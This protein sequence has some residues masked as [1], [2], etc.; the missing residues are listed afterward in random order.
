M[1]DRESKSQADV[2]GILNKT[3][4]TCVE[5]IQKFF[6][7]NM[8][9]EQNIINRVEPTGALKDATQEH[10]AKCKVDML[11]AFIRVRV[12]QDP[13]FKHIFP[14]KGTLNDAK[15]KIRVVRDGK[16]I[17]LLLEM[18]HELRH[19]PVLGG[20]PSSQPPVLVTPE[21]RPHIEQHIFLASS[22]A[23]SLSI[24]ACYTRLV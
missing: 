21:Q 5:K 14:K 9:C 3:L 2:K 17:P 18:A 12:F 15:D 7:N 10:F 8:Q 6:D 4:R 23:T 16:E 20:E 22:V 13:S 19:E 11:Q 24:F 1:I